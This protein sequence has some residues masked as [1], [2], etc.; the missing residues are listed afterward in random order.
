MKLLSPTVLVS[1]LA[2]AAY[3]PLA[4]AGGNLPTIADFV[5]GAD[6]FETL[7]AALEATGLDDP[8]DNKSGKFTVFA[9]KD[10]AFDN[11]PNGLL[12]CLLKDTD[13]L[14]DILKY[15]VVA[16]K[17]VEAGDLK[18][19]QKIKTLLGKNVKVSK[20]NKRV[21]INAS[22]VVTPDVEFKN[23]IVHVIDA[24]LVPPGLDVAGFLDDCKGGSGGG[25]N[26]DDKDKCHY[27]G[28]SAKHSKWLTGK[29][30][31]FLL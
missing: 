7:N 13:V 15:H 24:V 8:L 1:A 28:K 29:S 21:K 4:S 17:E 5:D 26:K 27:K 31:S 18:D 30:V 9:P 6:S 14:A 16:G 20:N 12:K 25:N 19:G 11:L 10:S 23:G 22:R 3:T 2:A